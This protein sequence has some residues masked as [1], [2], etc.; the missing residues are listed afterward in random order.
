MPPVP[1]P[2][3]A[4]D[5]LADTLRFPVLSADELA[6]CA[7]FG[8]RRVF[9]VDEE[10]FSAGDRPFPC[11]VLVAGEVCITDASTDDARSIIHFGAG[12]F[13]GDIDLLT[14]RPAV[15]S[16]HA[17]TPVE[18]IRILA[19]DLRRLFVR[20]PTLGEK[21]WRA[22]QR[23]REV[24]LTTAFRGLC[25]Y[26]GPH[27]RDTLESV[28][29]LFRNGVPH[30]WMNTADAE[31]AARVRELAASYGDT[32]PG[33]APRTP[34]ITYGRTLL[35]QN[36]GLRR[37]ADHLGLRRPLPTG[38]RDVLILGSGP[39]G[40]GAAVYAASEGLTTL[41]LD[42]LGPGGQAA[43]SSRIENYPG[44]PN[45]VA[46]RELAQL[47]YLQALKF[48][49]EFAA[50]CHVVELRRDGD[51]YRVRTAEGDEATGRTVIVATGVSYRLL[52][53][54]GLDDLHGAGVYYNAT[55]V[56]ALLCRNCPVHVVGAGNSAGQAAMFLS[57]HT[58]EISLVVRGGDLRKSMSSYLS[59]RVLANPRIKVRYHTQTT[60]VEGTDH[61]RAVHLRDDA[62]NVT[63]E[64]STGLFIFIGA[65]PRTNFL[66]PELARDDKGFAL[67]GPDVVAAGQWD[68]PRPPELLETSLS[69][70][71]AS[72]DC[73]SG[74]TKRVA[75]AIGDGALAVTCVHNLL[76]TYAV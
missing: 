40:L 55:A 37:L 67:T 20:E 17:V 61:L 5:L 69:G 34:V 1:A 70:V 49:A 2:F 50:P 11:F 41:V 71:F 15:V 64:E 33:D 16:C 57:Q 44:F 73:R 52:D 72:G 21:L 18:A 45:G 75:F 60:R 63:S 48:G 7:D 30:R 14:G 56:E 25:V 24:L 43:S 53:V 13:T 39:S 26:G 27:D 76:G 58:Q 35:F 36:P 38:P 46:G 22:M 19:G 29:F 66:P 32:E 31:H 4:A 28:E 23:R 65:R 10:L 68:G 59:E 47:S 54:A 62:G 3:P 42:G 74:T 12:H 8:L 9:A 6:R 51:V